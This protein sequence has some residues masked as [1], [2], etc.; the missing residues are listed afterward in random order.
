MKTSN[1]I[2]RLVALIASALLFA[3]VHLTS[4]ESGSDSA[5]T[6][7][8]YTREEL[9]SGLTRAIATHFNL[10]GDLQLELLR[11]WTP[12]V[13]TAAAWELNVTD[14]PAS[15]ASSMMMRCRLAA[16]GVVVVDTTF[17]V[18]AQLW[19]DAWVARTPLSVGALFDAAALETRRV[20]L[21][22]ERDVLPAT[23]GDRTYVFARTIAAGRLLTW[24]DVTR[25]PLVK[26]GD[27]VEV[28]ANDGPLLITMK[29]LAM[30]SGAQGD[31]VTVRNP[32]SRKN[33]SALVVD[34]NRVRVRF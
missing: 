8:P 1:Q 23:V 4:A 16:D 29:A 20:D 19:R 27:L 28:S 14:L 34:E 9:V 33:F 18:K 10:E 22:R 30:E 13:R 24:R 21:L 3:P 11:A 2:F 31:T 15:A 32:E 26:K 5:S 12:P 6:T 25:R 17:V 7:K